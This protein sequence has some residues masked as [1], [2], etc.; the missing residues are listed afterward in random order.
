MWGVAF[1][2]QLIDEFLGVLALVGAERDQPQPIG[3]RLDH[4]QRRDPLSMAVGLAQ[5]SVDDEAIAVLHQRAP[6]EAQLSFLARPLAPKLLE[7]PV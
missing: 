5:T 2:A 4:V 3:A 7:A 1:I 6:H